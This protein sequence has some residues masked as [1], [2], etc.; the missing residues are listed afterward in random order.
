MQ[1]ETDFRAAWQGRGIIQHE[2]WSQVL[3]CECHQI[4]EMYVFPRA[5]TTASS[6]TTQGRG[7]GVDLRQN[8][9]QLRTDG[10]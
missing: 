5:G 1:D 10:C 9:R 8:E 3:V 6:S 4:Q 2:G 7:G